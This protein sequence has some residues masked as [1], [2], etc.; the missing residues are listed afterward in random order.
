VIGF[1]ILL[2]VAAASIPVSRALIGVALVLSLS[3]VFVMRGIR[4]HRSDVAISL[5]QANT[6]KFLQ[7]EHEYDLPIV[8]ADLLTFM[9]LA[10]YAPPDLAARLVYLADPE[11]S[12]HYL[13]HSSADQGILE[14]KPWFPVK[15]ER[16]GS[17]VDS[18][19]RFLVYGNLGLFN[20]LFD[21]LTAA[22]MQIK[23]RGHHADKLLL[24]V[25]PAR[26]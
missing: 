9:P 20:W 6:Y 4:A 16:Y 15:I 12:L 24:L 17:Y 25:S 7:S 21:E 10:Y 23:L 5:D 26:P 3:G 14:L 8:V 13:G 22:E 19:R 2:A 18:Q 11:R 1:S